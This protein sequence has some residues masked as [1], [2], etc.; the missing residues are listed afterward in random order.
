AGHRRAR[1][2]ARLLRRRLGGPAGRGG[3]PPGV[4]AGPPG[5]RD[6]ERRR[7]AVR[8][9]ER[10]EGVHRAGR[11]RADRAR[12]AEAGHHGPVAA[13]RRPAADRRRRDRRAPARPSVRYRR[14]PV[15]GGLGAHRLRAAGAGA[16]PGDHRAVPGRAGRLPHGV[17]GRRAFHLLQRRLRRARAAG[18][19]G[20]R[21]AVPRPGPGHRAGAGGHGRHRVPAFGRAARAGGGRLRHRHPDQCLPPAGAG[22]R[23]RRRV[24]HRGRH[25]RLLGRP[26]RRADRAG[27]AGG[28]AGPAA[29][30]RHRREVRLRAGVLDLPGRAGRPAGRFGLRG[31]LPVPARPVHR[32]HVDG[33][34][35][36]LRR[37]VA[38]RQ[39]PRG[40]AGRRRP[41]RL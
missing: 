33:P 15:R 10:V 13:R 19:A 18:R 29:Q 11:R 17:P 35:Q 36:H 4:R 7:H 23:R 20:R 26:V 38:D 28:G 31:V 5:V 32:A 37:R 12:G 6:P 3:V 21:G 2:R 25:D 27:R 16:G 24:H 9:G 22:H 8:D 1:G 39:G 41:G 34:V 14:L 40:G 30:H